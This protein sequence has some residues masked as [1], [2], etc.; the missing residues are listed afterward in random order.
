MS[1]IEEDPEREERIRDEAIVDA[2]GPEEQPL[3]WY[4]YL[5]DKM[6]FPFPA[7]CIAERATSVLR[8]G[9]DI[10]VVG[11]APESECEHEMFVEI[12]WE[13]RA[14]AIPL[15]QVQ[16]I[17][18]TDADTKEAVEDWHYWMNRGYEF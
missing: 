6:S 7:K 4:Y 9:D 15:A 3:G 16:P 8:K 1:R 2:N 12:R 14:L 10:E 11:M 13:K 5:H 18:K 17:P